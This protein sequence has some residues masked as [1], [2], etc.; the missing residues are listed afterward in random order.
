[1]NERTKCKQCEF[2]IIHHKIELHQIEHEARIV[3]A[4]ADQGFCLRIKPGEQMTFK[5]VFQQLE[6]AADQIWEMSE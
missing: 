5:Q 3:R 4:D 2:P 1:M 6:S